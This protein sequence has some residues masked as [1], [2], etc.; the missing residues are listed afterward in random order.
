MNNE[1]LGLRKSRPLHRYFQGLESG[2]EMTV[3][4]LQHPVHIGFDE[5]V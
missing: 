2:M 5:L 4:M 3:M 1:V